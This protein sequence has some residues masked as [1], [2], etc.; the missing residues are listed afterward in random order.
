MSDKSNNKKTHAKIRKK[1]SETHENKSKSS[2]YFDNQ[3]SSQVHLKIGKGDRKMS[4][5]PNSNN[6]GTSEAKEAESSLSQ[7]RCGGSLRLE[8]SEY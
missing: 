7:G 8:S 6:E 2:D 4:V 5:N 3:V 1:G